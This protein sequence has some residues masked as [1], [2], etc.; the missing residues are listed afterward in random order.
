MA[1]PPHGQ[2]LMA[3][4]RELAFS[5]LTSGSSG[6]GQEVHSRTVNDMDGI[7]SSWATSLFWSGI[8]PGDTAYHMVPVGMT[9]GPNSMLFGF[10]NYG[11]HLFLVGGLEGKARLE[12]MQ[13]FRPH[14]FSTGPV[15]LRRL[16]GLCR[17][18][19]IDPRREFPSLKAIK[20]GSLG[21]ELD[22][23][24]ETEEFWGAKLVDTYASTQAGSGIASTCEHGVQRPDGVRAMMHFLEHKILIEVLDPQSGEPVAEDA[25]G[26]LVITSLDRA[27]VPVIRFATGDKVVFKSH[28]QCSCGRPYDGIEAGTVS[29][30]DSMMKIRGM[31]LWPEAV[32]SVV[33]GR[34]EIEEYNGRVFVAPNGREVVQLL[35]EFKSPCALDRPARQALLARLAAEV[36][37]RTNVSVQAEE[38]APGALQ[39]ITYK[40]KRWKDERR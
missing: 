18:M 34:V 22:W 37:D 9:S 26:E 20:L 28:R 15:Y 16:T 25:E 19:G 8:V 7:A 5:F 24:R 10:H 38:A 12:A 27:A 14:F 30:Y 40:E 13:R 33:F 21:Y 39:K 11:L 4:P 3:D 2:R 6:K 32:D 36:K 31:N 29:R 23:V 35:I 1:H 17:D